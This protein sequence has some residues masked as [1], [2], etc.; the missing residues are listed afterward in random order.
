MVLPRIHRLDR[1]PVLP[2]GPRGIIFL[3]IDGVLVTHRHMLDL[4]SHKLP[5]YDDYGHFF[6]PVC[7]QQLERIIQATKAD[8]VISSSWKM[9][10][11][12]AGMKVIWD[13][14]KLPGTV[15]DVTEDS[16]DRVRGFE[17]QRWL[18]RNEKEYRIPKV[19]IDDDS[20]MLLNQSEYFVQTKFETGLTEDLA[21]RAIEILLSFK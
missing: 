16:H 19:I 9:L 2:A 20:D 15:I 17:I 14:R 5:L 11:K 1:M 6:D 7:V 21:N 10:C 18:W 13:E 3:D 4:D 12:L 8:I